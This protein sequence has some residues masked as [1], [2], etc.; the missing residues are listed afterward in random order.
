MDKLLIIDVYNKT[1]EYPL[2][3]F[4]FED[5]GEGGVCI[6]LAAP[7]NIMP[8]QI[9]VMSPVARFLKYNHYYIEESHE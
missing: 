9:F 7:E 8:Y 5:Q 6:T 4:R 3:E 1:H 2:N